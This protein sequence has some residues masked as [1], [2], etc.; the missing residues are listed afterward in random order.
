MYG[1]GDMLNQ[2]LAISQFG[3]AGIKIA[4]AQCDTI[5]IR[6]F[7]IAG[8]IKVSVR[9]IGLSLLSAYPWEELFL[10][11]RQLAGRGPGF[12]GQRPSPTLRQ[13][14]TAASGRHARDGSGHMICETKCPVNGLYLALS[15]C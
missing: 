1:R 11:R 14:S 13:R 10:R 3:L 15:D 7:K 6:L 8:A 5:R 9:K 12:A 4:T 2:S